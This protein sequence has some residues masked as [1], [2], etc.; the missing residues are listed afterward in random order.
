MSLKDQPAFPST[1]EPSG[2]GCIPTHVLGMTLRQ[3]YAGQ[4]LMKAEGFAALLKE[5]AEQVAI[6]CVTYADALIAELDKANLE[7]AK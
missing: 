7:K 4:R 1:I 3:W 5:R 6:E 2:V